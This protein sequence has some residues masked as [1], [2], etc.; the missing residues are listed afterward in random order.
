MK[1]IVLIILIAVASVG[2]SKKC[3]ECDFVEV[4]GNGNNIVTSSQELCG[5]ALEA[6]ENIQGE[7]TSSS[8]GTG[9]YD[10]K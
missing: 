4:D 10:C 2:C 9:H 8:G 5:D 1:H 6:V 7:S 3:K